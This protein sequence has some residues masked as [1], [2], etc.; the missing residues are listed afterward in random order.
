MPPLLLWITGKAAFASHVANP[1][2]T[3]G[4]LR[5]DVRSA[6]GGAKTLIFNGF[7]LRASTRSSTRRDRG[8]RKAKPR[9]CVVSYG[10]S[11][12]ESTDGEAP[13]AAYRG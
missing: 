4:Y 6:S 9:Q 5:L 13:L 8:S 1:E 3:S 10:S 7:R 12:Q 11:R 2:T